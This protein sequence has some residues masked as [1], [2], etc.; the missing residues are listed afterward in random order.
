MAQNYFP[1]GM[2]LA[3]GDNA[4]PRPRS[5]SQK[6]HVPRQFLQKERISQ[7]FLHLPRRPYCHCLCAIRPPSASSIQRKIYKWFQSGNARRGAA[8]SSVEDGTRY[9]A[10]TLW[11]EA[12]MGRASNMNFD[13]P[14]AWRRSTLPGRAPILGSITRAPSFGLPSPCA[15]ST[16]FKS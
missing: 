6:W 1:S 16:Q 15:Y 2:F 9:P 12:A 11:T 8:A 10:G 14:F 5:S 13:P 4:S 3:L 7:G